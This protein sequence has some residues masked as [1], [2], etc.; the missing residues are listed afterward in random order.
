MQFFPNKIFSLIL[1]VI[2]DEYFSL[3]SETKKYV[4][5]L[6]TVSKI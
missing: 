5:N 6:L 4:V 1:N 2:S 3:H